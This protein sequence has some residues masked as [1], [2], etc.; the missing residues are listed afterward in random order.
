MSY[1]FRFHRLVSGEQRPLALA[2]NL[3]PPA[4]PNNN[5]EEETVAHA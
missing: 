5:S 3:A 2:R 4:V 1:N